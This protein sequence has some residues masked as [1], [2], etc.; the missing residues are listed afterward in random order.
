MIRVGQG[1][2]IHRLVRNRRFLLAGVEI[3]A[4]RGELGHS[5]GDV[6]AHAVCDAILGAAGLGDIGEMFPPSDPAY[7]DADSMVLLHTAFQRVKAAGWKVCNLD[8]IVLCEQPHVLPFRNKIRAAL[9]KVLETEAEAVF[10]KG[11]TTEGLG[12]IGK[13]RAVEAMAV[14]LLC[15]S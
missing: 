15:K 3:P 6:L 7:K 4:K 12:Q 14:C 5:D 11:K 2:D 8:C 13:G 9:A 1:Y 10:V